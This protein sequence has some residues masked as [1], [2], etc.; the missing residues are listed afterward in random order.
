MTRQQRALFCAVG[1]VPTTIA[2][3]LLLR[4]GC[5]VSAWLLELITAGAYFLWILKGVL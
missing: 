1:I 5:L 2:G 3:A 4:C